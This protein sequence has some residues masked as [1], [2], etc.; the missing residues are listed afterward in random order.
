MTAIHQQ[1]TRNDIAASVLREFLPHFSLDTKILLVENYSSVLSKELILQELSYDT[2][3][4]W[5]SAETAPKTW[6]DKNNYTTVI[7]RLP[8]SHEAF[9]MI[10]HAVSTVIN[11]DGNIIVYGLNDEGIKGAQSKMRDFFGN[12]DVR[13]FKKRV[14]II[15]SQVSREQPKKTKTCLKDFTQTASLL[16]K[17]PH[18]DTPL[19]LPTTFY[20]GM[21]ASGQLDNGTKFLLDSILL[22][23]QKNSYILDYGCGS[24][25]IAR[26]INDLYPDT[27]IDLL[28]RDIISLKAAK[29]NFPQNNNMFNT[30]SLAG[31]KENKYNLI[32]SNPPIHTEKEEH[33]RTLHQLI[34]TTPQYLKGDG[35]LILVAQNR[36]DLEEQFINAQMSSHILAE[37]SQFKVWSGKITD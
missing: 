33:Y 8:K 10:L 1:S 19:S 6:P 14:R 24:G 16:Y 15:S 3:N 35:K 9:D 34:A 29:I 4:R 18:I 11:D 31:C 20:P 28:D 32:I 21:F 17:P 2:W 5:W 13:G 30:D 37:N 25:I 7:I 22:S 23:I 12:N 26:I 27:K 36:I